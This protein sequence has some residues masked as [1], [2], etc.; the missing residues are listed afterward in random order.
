VGYSTYYSLLK[1]YQRISC[2]LQRSYGCA[3]TIGMTDGG[4]VR[5]A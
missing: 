4:D 3:Q 5:C 2:W 1:D